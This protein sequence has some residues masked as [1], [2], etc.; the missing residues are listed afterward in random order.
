[1]IVS[2]NGCSIHKNE[3]SGAISTS[4]VLGMLVGMGLRNVAIVGL[5]KSRLS[6]YFLNVHHT[7]P[8]DNY[9]GI[10]ILFQTCLR[11]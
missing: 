10:V 9:G 6:M 8:K 4:S 11:L 5:V 7:I 1:M 2:K 3:H